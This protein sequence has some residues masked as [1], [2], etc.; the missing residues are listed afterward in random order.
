MAIFTN[1]WDSWATYEKILL[2]ILLLIIISVIPTLVRIFTKNKRL[3]LASLFSIIISGFIVCITILVANLV[4]SVTITDIFK[5][6]P[7]I[8]IFTLTLSIGT[9][10]GYFM[11]NHKR[12]DFSILE[13]KTEVRNDTIRLSVS[14]LLL[15]IAVAV[16]SPSL[17]LP[18]LLALGDSLITLWLSYLLMCKLIK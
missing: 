16:L 7:F 17:I 10:V 14:L 6:V 18:L 8:T 1:L 9:T 13:I 4:F 15:L 2:G 5:I 11:Q 3:S 12:R